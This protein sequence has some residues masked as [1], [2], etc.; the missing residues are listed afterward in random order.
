VCA[1]FERS[2]LPKIEGIP[3]LATAQPAI[4]TNYGR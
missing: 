4:R 3:Y 2:S 1:L